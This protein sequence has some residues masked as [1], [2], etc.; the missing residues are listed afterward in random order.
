M[1]RAI[2]IRS[3]REVSDAIDI[4]ICKDFKQ[5]AD[6]LSQTYGLNPDGWEV[7]STKFDPNGKY[8][9]KDSSMKE[10]EKCSPVQWQQDY[11]DTQFFQI[12]LKEI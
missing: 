9:Y 1:I 11:K 6:F 5:S 3:C 4:T 7:I 2:V 10:S 8:S 12:H